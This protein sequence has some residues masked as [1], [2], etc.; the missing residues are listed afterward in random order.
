MHATKYALIFLHQ[1]QGVLQLPP[2]NLPVAA[3]QVVFR[4][5][6]DRPL[7]ELLSQLFGGHPGQIMGLVHH[8]LIVIGKQPHF[9]GRVGDQQGMVHYDQL[10]LTGS[11]ANGS[12]KAAVM[13]AAG[14]PQ[15][16]SA[17][18]AEHAPQAVVPAGQKA[19][20]LVDISSAGELF[21]DDNRQQLFAILRPQQPAGIA[22]HKFQP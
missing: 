16:E 9:I 3:A 5:V 4:Q 6:T 22:D 13:P 14:I 17:L 18:A 15:A 11:P 1:Q 7:P 20:A 2:E 10:G 12:Q 8:Q 21:P 19:G